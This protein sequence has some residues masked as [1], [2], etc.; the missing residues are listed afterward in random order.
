MKLELCFHSF[1]G[2]LRACGLAGVLCL[3][4][5]LPLSAS[6]DTTDPTETTTSEIFTTTLNGLGSCFRWTPKGICFWLVCTIYECHVDETLRIEHYTPDTTISTWHDPETHPWSDYGRTLAKQTGSMSNWMIGK[7]AGNA[8]G[9]VL[10]PDSA[11]TKTKG[12]RDTRNY[13]YR[14]ADAIGNPV[15]IVSGIVTGNFGTSSNGPSSI[16]VPLPYELAKWFTD[17]PQQVAS[18][19]AS[20]GNSASSDQTAFAQQQNSAYSS[21]LGLGNASGTAGKVIGLYNQAVGAYTTAGN[22]TN[23]NG[24]GTVGSVGGGGSGGGTGCNYGN[25]SGDSGG[26][27]QGGSGGGQQGNGGGADYLCPPGIMPFGLAFQSDL[28]SFFWRGLVPLES[29]YPA[30]WIP[31]VRE[32]GDGLAQTW[33]NVWPRT[34]AI[35]Q[36]HPVKGAAVFAQRVGD[37]ISYPAQP[38]IYAPLQLDTDPNYQFFGFQGIREHDEKHTLWQRV[39]PNPQS[40]CAIFGTNDSIAIFGFGDG[41]NVNSRGTVWNAWRKQDCCK[42]ATGGAVVFLFSVP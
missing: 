4:A 13:L 24:S 18:Q 26:E 41:Q 39:F 10:K 35:F 7:V 23:A 8:L 38:H 12:D 27:C 21:A 9:A 32:V 17:F 42:K 19:W 11:G 34:G 25:G 28:D 29:I 15:N 30:P 3:A 31:G 6:A 1:R 22:L 20:I 14:G 37:I 16:P 2:R 5:A 33:G 40:E 36:P